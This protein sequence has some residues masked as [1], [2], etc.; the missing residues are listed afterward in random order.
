MSGRILSEKAT[1]PTFS[2]VSNPENIDQADKEA[3]HDGIACLVL[4]L[5]M[6]VPPKSVPSSVVE[7]RVYA[8]CH[9]R[10]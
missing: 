8:R 2:K 4:V 9:P 3:E 6:H 1:E 5:T 7:L 10:K